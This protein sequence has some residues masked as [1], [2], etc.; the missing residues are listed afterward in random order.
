M[1]L[2]HKPKNKHISSTPIVPGLAA[3]KPKHHIYRVI[4]NSTPIKTRQTHSKK[5]HAP[6]QTTP[7]IQQNKH[8]RKQ[9]QQ[10]TN[11]NKNKKEK[12]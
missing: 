4:A 8:N 9:T 7:K 12:K 3:T 6:L 10:K 2:H 1:F 5:H 11:T